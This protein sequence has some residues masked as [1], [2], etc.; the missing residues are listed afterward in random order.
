MWGWFLNLNLAHGAGTEDFKCGK[1]ITVQPS[2]C[3]FHL[4]REQGT[5]DRRDTLVSITWCTVLILRF[6]E[7]RLYVAQANQNCLLQVGQNFICYL[8]DKVHLALCYI[9]KKGL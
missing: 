4:R 1:T 8:I 2:F 7:E 5:C 9:A 6:L 3:V